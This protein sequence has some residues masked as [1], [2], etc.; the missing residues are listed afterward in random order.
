[1]AYTTVKTP[2]VYYGGKTAILNHLLPMVPAH[3]CYLEA[4]AGGATLFW[5]KEPVKNETINDQLKIVVNFYR[6]LKNKYSPLKRMIERTLIGRDIHNEALNVVRA[7]KKGLKVDSVKLA[8]AFWVCTNFAF[9]NKIGGGYK[10][11]NDMSVSVPDTLIKRKQQFTEALVT[12]IEHAYIENDDAIKI[13]KSRNTKKTFTYLDPPYPGT[14]QGHYSGKSLPGGNKFTFVEY[15]KLLTWCAEECA[16][17]F[18]LSGYNTEMLSSFIKA[19]GWFKKEITHKV[20]PNHP[21]RF[22]TKKTKTEVL[23]SNY[24]TPCGTLKLF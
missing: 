19:N 3:E 1:M 15:E 8:W 23:V 12:R 14:D 9:S 7:H 4:Y 18:L 6:T 24:D 10:Y 2:I 20:T 21:T 22:T 16:G 5:A 11:S 13:A 17:N